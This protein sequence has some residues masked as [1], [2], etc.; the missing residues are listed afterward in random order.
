M[1]SKRANPNSSKNPRKTKKVKT[2]DGVL[3]EVEQGKVMIYRSSRQS[4][5]EMLIKLLE[6]GRV[7]KAELTE[8]VPQD[9][10]ELEVKVYSL[11]I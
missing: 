6:S 9:R 2:E 4:L 5:E 10:R 8:Q 11:L 7:S 3:S 1:P